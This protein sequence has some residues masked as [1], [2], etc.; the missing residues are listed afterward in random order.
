M[1]KSLHL[2]KKILIFFTEVITKKKVENRVPWSTN[3][4]RYSFKGQTGDRMLHL[5]PKGLII[6][7]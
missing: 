7:C 6:Y 1:Q 4:C 2:C 3:L 5:Y